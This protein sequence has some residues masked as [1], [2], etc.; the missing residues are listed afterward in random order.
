MRR[1]VVYTL[2]PIARASDQF[3]DRRGANRQRYGN[4]EN[5][6]KSKGP[7]NGSGL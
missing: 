7:N 3:S 2:A 5:A 4:H 6:N 1:P